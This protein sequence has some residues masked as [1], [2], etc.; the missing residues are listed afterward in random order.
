MHKIANCSGVHSFFLYSQKGLE[1][2]EN[3]TKYGHNYDQKAYESCWN[4]NTCI[5]N[6]GYNI[7]FI[8]GDSYI[9]GDHLEINGDTSHKEIKH[10]TYTKESYFQGS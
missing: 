2:K 4:F 1:H 6:V 7:Q 10:I 5:S 3:Q 8:M 9:Y